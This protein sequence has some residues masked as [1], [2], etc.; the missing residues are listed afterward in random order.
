MF[1]NNN[2]TVKASLSAL[3]LLISACS[4]ATP[5]NQPQVIK[6]SGVKLWADNCTRCHNMRSP[7]SYS[8]AQWNIAILHMRVRANLTADDARAI[9]EYLKSAN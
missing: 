6:K 9:A 4:F 8:D 7:D 5:S 2:F 3:L 1:R